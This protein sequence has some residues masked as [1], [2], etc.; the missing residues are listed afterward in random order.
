M[1]WS[2]NWLRK[3]LVSSKTSSD[4]AWSVGTFSHEAGLVSEAAA[5]QESPEG[6]LVSV[7]LSHFLLLFSPV[8]CET[9]QN[10]IIFCFLEVYNVSCN[11]LRVTE[12]LVLC[13]GSAPWRAASG[14]SSTCLAESGAKRT[15]TRRRDR[16]WPAS[17]SS[18]TT[19][20]GGRFKHLKA[21]LF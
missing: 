7:E 3:Q 15:K 4:L 6:Q 9:K 11:F 19:I 21:L 12:S 18:T 13:S 8:E 17:R 2:W 20:W 14:R 10:D 16:C 5:P 1:W